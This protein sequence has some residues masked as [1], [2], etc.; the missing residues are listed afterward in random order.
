MSQ[1]T[2]LAAEFPEVH[3][4]AIQAE[5][6]ARGDP[7]SACVYAR[8][9][10][11]TMVN[12]LYANEPS[13]RNPYERTLAA[14]IHEPTFQALVG[15]A[16]AAK[17]R[18][19]KDQ[20]NRAAHEAKAVAPAAAVGSLRELFHVSYWLV[21]T[22]A[23]GAKPAP[24]V[25][26]SADALPL[27]AQVA[28][29]KLGQLQEVARRFADTVAAR[30][31]ADKARLASEEERDRVLAEN[32]ALQAE[33]AQVRAANTRAADTHDFD[34]AT[35]RDQFIDL[36]LAEA[37]WTFTRPGHD[38]EYPVTGMPNAHGDGYVDYVLWGDDGKPLA[39]VEAKRTKKDPRVGQRQAE[40]YAD[41]L[42]TQF[43]Q[44]PVVFYTNGY[45]HWMWDD[46][47]GYPPRPVAGFLTK[48]QLELAIR[49]RQTLKPLATVDIDS[50]IVERPYQTRAIRRVTEAFEKDR[51]RRALLVMAT[52]SGKT[53]TV[54]ALTDV[55]MRANWARRV[56]FLADRV[57]LVNQ[58]VG[59]FKAFLP[60]AS[61]VNLVTDKD[62][63]GRVFVSTYPTMMGLIN[64]GGDGERRFGPGHFDLIIIDEA[65]RSV[66][67]KYG[68]IFDYFDS[69]LVGLTATPKAEVDHDTYRL[70]N[71]QQGVPTDAYSLDEAIADKHLVP[72][73]AI[74]VPLKFERQG[75]RYDDLSEDEKEAWD[76]IEW[77][78][79]GNVPALVD[80]A[81]LN[82]WLFNKDTVDKVLEHLMTH[83]QKVADGDRLGKTIIFA[84]NQAHARFIVE[85]FDLAYPHL[86]GVFARVIVSG[87]P[88]A[89]S[90]L[91]D[92]S[93]AEKAPHIAV[94]VDMLDT[95]VDV[96]EILNLVFFKAVRSKTK[97]WQMLGRGT[98][99]RKNLFGPGRDKQYFSVFDFCQNLEFFKQNPDV[100]EGAA[101]QSLSERLFTSRVELIAAIDGIAPER[102]ASGMAEGGAD[103][104]G[105]TTLRGSIV[106][107]LRDEVAGMNL[108]NFLV[109]P[110]RRL[111]EKFAQPQAW[112]RL[113]L[114]AQ[115]ELVHGLAGLP[116]A[117]TDDDIAAK[118]F[119]GLMMRAQLSLLRA[120]A[121]YAGLKAK[122]I[123]TAVLL[124][125]KSN[126]PMVNRELALIQEIQGEDFWWGVTAPMLETVRRKLRALI[127]LI[128]PAQR[129]II[130][131]DFEDQIGEGAEVSLAGVS[132]GADMEKFRQKALHFLRGHE[133]HL[134]V[135]KLRRNEPL[136]TTDLGELERIFLDAGV[137]APDDIERL[138]QEGGLG[139][140]VRSLVGL[141]REAAKAAF[142]AFV[143]GRTL[144]ANQIEFLNLVID[145]LT[146][147]GQME[148]R[149]LYE[150]PFTDFDP[151]GVS[152][153]FGEDVGELIEILADVK[154]RAA[155]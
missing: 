43:G 68:A 42:Q 118:Q 113:D 44:R 77:D 19:I 134:A 30:D 133:D 64:E 88:Y 31:A 61:P 141:D 76:A 78:E 14:R 89:Q 86:A 110:Q 17:T 60:S 28:A 81:A 80:P 92:F 67:R 83:G 126:I 103:E 24:D 15:Q 57:A 69:L 37:G 75:I 25:A 91:D 29:Q 41:C 39:V 151:L 136:T 55:L 71:L 97:F 26:F 4:L 116:S 129:P 79:D 138:R 58:A 21:R 104:Q 125:D 1:F 22:Y 111:V 53:R 100:S 90:L 120:E 109:R 74:S 140:F 32:A 144:T 123:Q 47:R 59:A 49:R 108:D 143:A 101:G 130:Y 121:A 2:F 132:V 13:L 147:R 6:I 99:L 8:L 154:R 73:K 36:L 131:T 142:S 23:R 98:R 149:L 51:L 128:E 122:I 124:E 38:T 16:V 102:T 63:A 9:A 107:L 45:E 70:F 137:A 3:E 85:R 34:E 54:I 115:A 33:I 146:E 72:F 65:H 106:D 95:G 84:K 5:R 50:T 96:P 93:Q 127:K 135:Q 94:S 152:G 112:G 119:D 117:V 66:Y 7:R 52:G 62:G 87:E 56:L 155:A 105:L 40:L 139:L 35:T 114:D 10:L 148:P 27:N 153:M 46:A 82:R 145:H 20:G 150:S 11:E 18:L 48:D 12:W